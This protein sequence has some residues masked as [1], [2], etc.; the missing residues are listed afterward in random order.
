MASALRAA[1]EQCDL[2]VKKEVTRQHCILRRITSSGGFLFNLKIV[3]SLDKEG[4]QK[5][6]TWR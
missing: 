1:A 6:F 2:L 5:R 4:L 3:S